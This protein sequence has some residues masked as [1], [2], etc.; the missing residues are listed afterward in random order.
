MLIIS[1]YPTAQMNSWSCYHLSS[2]HFNSLILHLAFF[3]FTPQLMD[4]TRIR[5]HHAN[6]LMIFV[7]LLKFF[8]LKFFILKF[9]ILKFFT[10]GDPS[11]RGWFS[12]DP[13]TKSDMISIRN[14]AKRQDCKG[15]FTSFYTK[16]V[17]D[18][19]YHPAVFSSY[20]F[21]FALLIMFIIYI[22]IKNPVNGH[23]LTIFSQI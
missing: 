13:P 16:I 11:A 14:N 10:E 3:I 7:F 12:R 9:F 6:W 22:H 15:L 2:P 4:Y 8:I 18:H 5:V 21:H 17:T 23:W 1:S 19:S 20:Y